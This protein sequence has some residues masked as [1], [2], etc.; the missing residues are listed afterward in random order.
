MVEGAGYGKVGMDR[1][2]A[3]AD[4]VLRREAQ[5]ANEE[6]GLNSATAMRYN[7]A[8]LKY[9]KKEDNVREQMD[10]E[11]ARMGVYDPQKVAAA[12]RRVVGK[13]PQ[14]GHTGLRPDVYGSMDVPKED[15]KVEQSSDYQW[16]SSILAPLQAPPKQQPQV[17]STMVIKSS[18]EVVPMESEM[19]FADEDSLSLGEA[20]A[21]DNLCW[22]NVTGNLT[23]QDPSSHVCTCVNA[24][25]ANV[26]DGNRSQSSD[27]N[28]DPSMFDMSCNE[29]RLDSPSAWCAKTNDKKQWYQFDLL[30]DYLV[31]GVAT[32]GRADIYQWVTKFTVQAR[33]QKNSTWVNVGGNQTKHRHVNASNFVANTD[34]NTKV[35]NYF[36]TPIK[37]RYIR[38]IPTAWHDHIAMRVALL[39]DC[40]KGAGPPPP[41][42]KP[43]PF[44]PPFAPQNLTTWTNHTT[45]A[46]GS[47]IRVTFHDGFY[48]N[49][50]AGRDSVKLVS[51]AEGCT[52]GTPIGTK[53]GS[54]L[55][56]TNLSKFSPPPRPTLF[57][58][59]S[60]TPV[61]PPPAPPLPPMKDNSACGTKKDPADAQ[62]T[63]SS[64]TLPDFQPT[65]P[66]C[67]TAVKKGIEKKYSPGPNMWNVKAVTLP[68]PAK[69]SSGYIPGKCGN[70][71]Y[72]NLP[73]ANRKN[74]GKAKAYQ[75]AANPRDKGYHDRRRRNEG[76]KKAGQNS[77]DG[78]LTSEG[79]D[80]NDKHWSTRVNKKTYKH[81]T[82]Y[83]NRWRW[84]NRVARRRRRRGRGWGRRRRSRRR[85]RYYERYKH[86]YKQ[87]YQQRYHS[88]W[89][90]HYTYDGW[91]PAAWIA[92]DNGNLP[93]KWYQIDLPNNQWVGGTVI[94]GRCGE[95]DGGRSEWITGYTVSVKADK[96]GWYSIPE[97]FKG[98]TDGCL[99]VENAF[100]ISQLAK[101]IKFVPTGYHGHISGRFG[102]SFTNCKWHKTY[103]TDADFNYYGDFK[104]YLDSDM[105]WVARD[106]NA[107]QWYE[108]D[109]GWDQW[110]SGVTTQGR[111]NADQW[112]TTYKVQVMAMSNPPSKLNPKVKWQTLNKWVL[113][114]GSFNGNKDRDSKVTNHFSL[115]QW[116]RKIKITPTAWHGWV[117][118]RVGFAV[119]GCKFATTKTTADQYY[120]GYMQARLD[121]PM[122]WVAKSKDGDAAKKEWYTLDLK[123][124]QWVGGITT[125]GRKDAAQWVT[126][127]ELDYMT[128]DNKWR[129][130]GAEHGPDYTGNA[131]LKMPAT[132]ST[133]SGSV[134]DAK[135]TDNSAS[136][137]AAAA[138]LDA[139][140]A[141]WVK[142]DLKQYWSIAMVTI[143]GAA[144]NLT[145][146]IGVTGT[147]KD[148]ICKAGIDTTVAGTKVICPEVTKGRYL[149][150]WGATP[151]TLCEIKA[152]PTS[153]GWYKNV[154]GGDGFIKLG[155]WRFGNAKEDGSA[156]A[157]QHEDGKLAA[158]MTSE[159]KYYEGDKIPESLKSID[160][161]SKDKD[162]ASNIMF[163]DG[164][165][166]FA[167]KWRIG[168]VS[169]SMIKDFKRD[170]E[171]DIFLS[172]SHVSKNTSVVWRKDGKS[173]TGPRISHSTWHVPKNRYNELNPMH[174][175]LGDEYF[176]LG[177]NWRIGAVGGRRKMAVYKVADCGECGKSWCDSKKW[178]QL[179]NL[180]AIKAKFDVSPKKLS[181][182]SCKHVNANSWRVRD[183]ATG[184]IYAGIE[185]QTAR[186]QIHKV[187]D[188]NQCG[189]NWCDSSHK[190]V[191]DNQIVEQYFEVG[192]ELSVWGC[193]E[194]VE[195]KDG[196]THRT[197]HSKH[198][199]RLN[200]AKT[201]RNS[202]S[203]VIYVVQ[204]VPADG[205]SIVHG[206]TVVSV[207]GED[208]KTTVGSE[209]AAAAFKLKRNKGV[210]FDGNTD[211]NTKV[212][213]SFPHP[214]WAK[215]IRIRPK[216]HSK[217]VAMRV[218][219]SDCVFP[220]APPS[221]SPALGPAPPSPRGD[222]LLERA[223]YHSDDDWRLIMGVSS[224]AQCQ[225]YC[226][227]TGEKNAQIANTPQGHGPHM[228][229]IKMHKAAP[230]SADSK[231]ETAHTIRNTTERH[232]RYK[233]KD[234]LAMETKTTGKRLIGHY[235]NSM[236]NNQSQIDNVA[237]C[238]RAQWLVDGAYYVKKT[239]ASDNYRQYW[240]IQNVT[241]WTWNGTDEVKGEIDAGGWRRTCGI[242]QASCTGWQWKGSKQWEWSGGKFLW[243]GSIH[244]TW[245]SD[246]YSW[247]WTGL[248]A[249]ELWNGTEA[250]LKQD[251]VVNKSVPIY[252]APKDRSANVTFVVNEVMKAPYRFCY[253]VDAP[254]TINMTYPN[255]TWAGTDPT[256]CNPGDGSGNLNKTACKASGAMIS[257]PVW[258][259]VG[260]ELN[261]KA[262]M[263]KNYSVS[264]NP[265]VVDA[266]VTIS[267]NWGIALNNMKFGDEAKFVLY[268]SSNATC[269]YPPAKLKDGMLA[270]TIDLDKGNKDFATETSYSLEFKTPGRYL[271]CY[272]LRTENYTMIPPLLNIS[273]TLM[274]KGCMSIGG[275]SEADLGKPGVLD[276]F[277]QVMNH[278][279]FNVTDNLKLLIKKSCDDDDEELGEEAEGPLALEYESDLGER[280]GGDRLLGDWAG[281]NR[282][283]LQDGQPPKPPPPPPS[284]GL[285][286]WINDVDM[287]LPPLS[288]PADKGP[289]MKAL[290]NFK[291]VAGN[292]SPY[293]LG[294]VT[295]MLKEKKLG[296]Y[297]NLGEE[298]ASTN[299]TKPAQ[300]GNLGFA[301]LTKKAPARDDPTFDLP[302][303]VKRTGRFHPY[304]ANQNNFNMAKEPQVPKG[305]YPNI[306]GRYDK[307]TGTWK[308]T[309]TPAP[310]TTQMTAGDRKKYNHRQVAEEK[311][312]L[313][314]MHYTKPPRG[315]GGPVSLDQADS[316]ESALRDSLGESAHDKLDAYDEWAVDMADVADVEVILDA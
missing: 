197:V 20:P 314:K 68:E 158:V 193:K 194:T 129:Q 286:Y 267:Y 222:C 64:V 181:D 198:D 187:K 135:L 225:A 22:S 12:V 88:G 168:Y 1:E 31:G 114:D 216:E 306:Q 54:P 133:E 55:L 140:N 9:E 162:V 81:R 183:A 76:E 83:H 214:I 60:P 237:T 156:F 29:P 174:V 196:K 219:L 186:P 180:D 206:D 112:V 264:R 316:A 82:L 313:F 284:A 117:S 279:L 294:N 259:P 265:M 307:D 223:R 109:A 21:V 141:T 93:G 38:I 51:A 59:P 41:P 150:V 98:N 212:T 231:A 211:Q 30:G 289:G 40:T 209:A 242:T 27:L 297:E 254:S 228:Q 144:T 199:H 72:R 94:Q 177:K 275:Y 45:Y 139:K 160:L 189:H 39:K 92:P 152:Y 43:P 74:S 175:G 118:M 49:R 281:S 208:G 238:R 315:K 147:T 173:I 230:K 46:A 42:P 85:R 243:K 143:V 250:S 233:Y 15:F 215:K 28:V 258:V 128:E 103:K 127:Y 23:K 70:N 310:D 167:E 232:N 276:V 221:P 105:A 50:T 24:T 159:G 190:R 304:E 47:P 210:V 257:S 154:K 58:P 71:A 131:A 102:V 7:D 261:V 91:R 191:L 130:I 66:Q 65:E 100:P 285:F 277:R 6:T 110:I 107:A 165:I 300:I 179:G 226:D 229:S 302:S 77:G 161:K 125:Q 69:A 253:K 35:D 132:I 274:A 62:R 192:A 207:L 202:V 283:L 151:L 245:N 120:Y 148:I 33:T 273:M 52:K 178:E 301:F 75:P 166:E 171:N 311:A 266:W 157:F 126:K 278:S 108:L 124:E 293:Y 299:N 121:D 287:G 90:H 268:N 217:W 73:V 149:T 213:T 305:V 235:N 269:E 32:Q 106:A 37:A 78:L 61:P 4:L 251:W 104:G 18:H 256:K 292:G 36:T 19:D 10:A 155:R 89:T 312:R 3:R 57:A 205:F 270:R 122:A 298:K 79:H 308:A 200:G 195:Q 255:T 188:C 309:P 240:V 204:E 11:E 295:K 303:Y 201:V 271:T 260:P 138:A 142:V 224:A 56:A 164:I 172:L 248:N 44:D 176:Q 145:V 291:A 119:K 14:L 134:V 136:S 63:A 263:P 87:A 247:T 182:M 239:M 95:G 53:E 153:G 96:S 244:W 115:A 111:K 290:D 272:K 99:K 84:A 137:C 220:R 234:G 241:W 246:T 218:G 249:T 67:Y 34:Q 236:Y 169:A 280:R 184:D 163:G 80:A 8:V 113:V 123:T 227:N 101:H 288:N 146:R 25:T 16:G 296:P 252:K 282:R 48:L 13:P 170:H 116:G 203:G 262:V 2:A 26:P 86:H 97:T 17:A 185:K 5:Q